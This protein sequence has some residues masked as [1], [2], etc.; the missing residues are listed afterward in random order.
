MNLE[1]THT[2]ATGVTQLRH[3]T[4]TLPRFIKHFVLAGAAYTPSAVLLARGMGA[5]A[6]YW[7]FVEPVAL[8]S[9]FFGEP[10]PILRD[11][12]LKAHFSNLT[13]RAFADFLSRKI[14][15]SWIT[16]SYEGVLQQYGLSVVGPRPDLLALSS[17][18]L[19]VAIEAKGYAKRSV[20]MNEM[21]AHKNQAG[22]GTL[23]RHAYAA[24]VAYSLYHNAKVKYL[25]PEDGMPVPKPEATR[26]QARQYFAQLETATHDINGAERT[27]DGRQFTALPISEFIRDHSRREMDSSG[28]LSAVTLLI[29]GSGVSSTAAQLAGPQAGIERQYV[30]EDRLPTIDSEATFVD[31]DG[32]GVSIAE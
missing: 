1:V 17:S 26:Q 27:I 12:T 24:S 31:G 7:D 28:F 22:Q 30:T 29:D 2:D 21:L 13:G 14:V 4:I 6:W 16:L 19:V 32:I 8:G 15:G 25:D 10:I 18:S 5:L 23:P 3:Y 20:S 11:P 9:N